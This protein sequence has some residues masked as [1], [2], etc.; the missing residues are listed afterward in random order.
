MFSPIR[1]TNPAVAVSE[2]TTHPC[3]AALS[4]AALSRAFLPMLRGPVMWSANNHGRSCESCDSTP[5][6]P[7]CQSYR[8]TRVSQQIGDGAK[9]EPRWPWCTIAGSL[10]ST[11]MSPHTL[12]IASNESFFQSPG[13]PL[14]GLVMYEC[15]PTG[16]EC[17]L[18]PDDTFDDPY[19]FPGRPR[20][21]GLPV[22]ASRSTS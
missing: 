18:F 8:H 9:L 22:K 13:W 12:G 7:C 14:K 4:R 20:H 2:M 21:H 10:I 11:P 16:M 3:W 19:A 17:E 15:A 6:R 5:R 1:P